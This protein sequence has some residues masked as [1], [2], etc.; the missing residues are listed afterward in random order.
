MGNYFATSKE[1]EFNYYCK[2]CGE[3][4]LLHFLNCNFDIICSNHKILSIP[5]EQFYTYIGVDS[6]YCHICKHISKNL[7]FCYE[8][9]KN[10]CCKCIILHNQYINNSHKII[11]GGEKNIKCNLHYKNFNRFCLKCKINL[12]ELCENHKNHYIEYF[13]DIYPLDEDIIEFN[14]LKEDILSL[15]NIKQEQINEINIKYLIIKSFSKTISNYNYIININN[16]INCTTKPDNGNILGYQVNENNEDFVGNFNQKKKITFID[17]LKNKKDENN[18]ENKIVFKSV[19]KQITQDF[20]SYTWCMKK[21]NPILISQDKKLELI[22]IGGSNRK[23]LIF[24]VLTFK[25]HQI[26]EEHEKIVYS[27]DQFKND[28]KFLFSSSND[29]T[30]NVYK[31]NSD[32]RYEL[33]QKLKKSKDKDGGEI[34]K[35]ICLSNKLL[36]TG[37]HR[38]ITIWNLNKER[39]NRIYFEDFHEIILNRDTCH[40]LELNQNIFIAIQHK[41]ETF[42]VYKNNGES[43]PLIGELEKIKSHGFSSNGLCKINDNLVCSPYKNLFHIIS[44]KPLQIIQKIKIL[45]KYDF[46]IYYMNIT[47]DSYLYCNSEFQNINQY[48]IIYDENNNFSELNEIGKYSREKDNILYEKAIITFEDGRIFL[49]EEKEGEYFYLLIA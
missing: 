18:I 24:N 27:L 22:G 25:I 30:I 16:I 19:N 21:L 9:N 40:L 1:K 29:K 10:Y 15:K 26:I 49:V 2:K 6:H 5:I 23:I 36:V 12:C 46:I 42:Q 34:N 35:V 3:I 33:V 4:P 47:N 20:Y 31:L 37:D 39:E 44:I 7:L 14:H 43:F 11:N 28:P 17:D 41:S 32:N 13:E 38:S 48:K 8:C 45:S